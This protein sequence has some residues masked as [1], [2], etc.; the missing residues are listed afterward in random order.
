MDEIL[1]E[2]I[3]FL[4]QSCDRLRK[5]IERF[6]TPRDRRAKARDSGIATLNGAS[7]GQYYDPENTVVL[8]ANE[9]RDDIDDIERTSHV[10]VR[11]AKA[12]SEGNTSEALLADALGDHILGTETAS[13]PPAAGARIL[14]SATLT[15]APLE[16]RNADVMRRNSINY[17]PIRE[18][19][20]ESRQSA[21]PRGDIE[22]CT[23]PGKKRGDLR[24][25][26][27]DESAQPQTTQLMD[28]MKAMQ[29][30]LD[31]LEKQEKG[32][33]RR[34][35]PS[36]ESRGADKKSE[37]YRKSPGEGKT[38]RIRSNRRK[39]KCM[40]ANIGA[41]TSNHEA[42]IFLQTKVNEVQAKMLIDTGAS[43]TLISKKIYDLMPQH[44]RPILEASLQR[45]LNASGD[46]LPQYGRAIF[47]IE[48][49]QSET[50]IPAI[51]TD[52][53]VYGILGLDFLKMG[54]G[55]INLGT[56]T[57]RLNDEEC[58][59]SCEGAMGCYRITAADDVHI[60]PRSEL[61]I[62]GKIS[63]E[64][65]CGTIDYIVAPE[66]KFLERGRALVGRTLVKGGENIPV[67]LMNITDVPQTI[68]TRT[69]P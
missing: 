26:E 40:N 49:C 21:V 3:S 51:V 55:I 19:Q 43:L 25:I 7:G 69:Q 66:E 29:T 16:R 18:L 4:E 32:H 59:V 13:A 58:A 63:G 36:L 45:V 10:T 48:V 38:R 30:K 15:R 52:I 35:C 56:N 47:G 57:L 67:R 54:N 41:N 44:T 2:E 68:C 22:A 33:I 14:S 6:S 9:V 37:P 5:E 1:D 8:Q 65:K 50:H 27:S 17:A 61:V 23:D 28:L 24:M 60:P 11:R 46:A 34:N 31:K 20:T 62:K 39:N 12:H 53:T 42:G 64:N